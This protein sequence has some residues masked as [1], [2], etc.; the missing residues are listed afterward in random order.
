MNLTNDIEIEEDGF[1]NGQGNEQDNDENEEENQSE[2]TVKKCIDELLV[3]VHNYIHSYTYWSLLRTCVA[4]FL[5]TEWIEDYLSALNDET[6]ARTYVIVVMSIRLFEKMDGNDDF[7]Q[8][9]PESTYIGMANDAKVC[10][11]ACPFVENEAIKRNLTDEM[12][13]EQTRLY[14]KCVKDTFN[15]CNCNNSS[16]STENEVD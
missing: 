5:E 12:K 8:R 14:I 13:R 1:I 6:F 7:K 10:Y 16:S 11:D 9:T 3:H 4:R 15:R 2:I